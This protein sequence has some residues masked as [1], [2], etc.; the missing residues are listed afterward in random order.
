MLGGPA[1]SIGAGNLTV[2]AR[3]GAG[4]VR[5]WGRGADGLLGYANVNNIGDNEHANAAG[6]VQLF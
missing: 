4:A 1:L 5:C 6:P 3:Y 2:C